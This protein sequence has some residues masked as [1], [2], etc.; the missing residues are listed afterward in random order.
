VLATVP[1]ITP[2]SRYDMERWGCYWAFTSL[3]VRRLFE[4]EFPAQG[5]EVEAHGNVLAAS[6]FLYGMATEELEQSELDARD[7][8]YQVVITIRAV[9]PASSDGEAS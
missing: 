9:R 1:G 7:P 6:A 5:V 4:A 8:D 3:S 2:I